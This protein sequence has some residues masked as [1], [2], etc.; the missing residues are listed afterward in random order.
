MGLDVYVGPLTRYTLGA[1]LTV[2][3]RALQADGHEVRMVHTGPT[4]KDV[5]TDPTVV[6]D[7]VLSWQAGLL[8]ALGASGG[9]AD[10]AG[11]PYWTAKPDWDGYGGMVLLAAYDEQPELNP[12]TR[13][14]ILR[15]RAPAD[16]PRDLQSAPAYHR[17][18]T[19]PSRYPSLLSGV[20]W[21]LPVEAAPPL[22]ELP[23]LTGQPTRMS[24][25]SQL[26]A[27][28]TMLAGRIGMD[29]VELQRRRQEG[30]PTADSDVETAGRYGLAVFSELA[31]AALQARQPLLLDY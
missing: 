11:L 22:F 18:S 29:D 10:E 17:A 25:V 19:H 24:H 3:Q 1:W 16:S 7:A 28:L 31:Q 13:T 8:T 21:W 2:V 14:G 26:V 6:A 4:Q 27:E 12:A 9:W 30:P 15:R 20:E 23:R 5:I